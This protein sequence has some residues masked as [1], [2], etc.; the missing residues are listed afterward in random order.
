MH[1]LRPCVIALCASPA[2]AAPLPTLLLGSQQHSPLYHSQGV[3]Q[4]QRSAELSVPV[5]GR[6]TQ[7][8]VRAGDNV[9]AGT[10]LARVDGEAARQ[11]A[12][13]SQ[14]QIAAAQAQLAQAQREF[15]RTQ[16]LAA[17]NFISASALD[18]AQ[19]QLKTAEAQARAQMATVRASGAQA[20]LY[21]LSAPFAGTIARV[22]GDLG[23]LA[24]PGQ[25]IVA[26]Y[27]G[28]ALRVEVQL[29][30]SVY[31]NLNQQAAPVLSWRGQALKVGRIEWFPSTDAGSQTRTVRI[32]LQAGS[33]VAVG[34][35]VQAG[36]SL[37]GSDSQLRVPAAA[38]SRQREFD[39]VYVVD[40]SGR[41]S[42][43]FVRLGSAE[44]GTFPVLAGLRAGE[45]IAANAE[46]AATLSTSQAG[47][48]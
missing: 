42:L 27:D 48:R 11:S 38:V 41:A 7:L 36:F 44:N 13:A 32:N 1:L 47:A 46:Q 17:Q 18:A 45:R 5:S 10:V 23:A 8:S 25:A 40:H 12:S 6:I 28:S 21:Q 29:P 9:K 3:V 2:L 39:T 22:N 19:A 16:K 20:G 26:M 30:A 35:M 14:A 24:M 34:E 4:A 33:A 15:A 37:R 31:A 43:R